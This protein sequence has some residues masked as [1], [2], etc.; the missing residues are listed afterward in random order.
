MKKQI[1]LAVAGLT[2]ACATQSRAQII[3]DDFNVDEG[4]FNL[5]P[6]FAGQTRGLAAGS[7]AD[8]VT[9]DNPLEG[10]GH[11]RLLLNYDPEGTGALRVRH[12]SG[13][14]NVGSNTPFTTSAGQ[15]GFIGYYVRTSVEGLSTQ[16]NLD[17]PGG[18]YGSPSVPL[19]ADGLW[20]LYEWSLDGA[21]WGTV[22]GIIAR[23]PGALPDG[24]HTIDSIY[25]YDADAAPSPS[26]EYFLDFVALNPD[27]S[28]AE[29]VPVPEPSTY[30]M[31][32]GI[33]A[34]GGA[35]IHRRRTAKA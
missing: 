4:H 15:D 26:G 11:Q 27:G 31:I 18:M 6:S 12:L 14:G 2:L 23:T 29:L 25:F 10:D 9:T 33:L 1:L 35:I 28:V 16:L 7:S 17:S 30:A 21:V 8:R 19:I 5:A 22:P 24:S 34:L 20:H 13:G 3:F 32:F